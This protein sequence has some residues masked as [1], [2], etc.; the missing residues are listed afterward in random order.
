M[1]G[2]MLDIG[3]KI[4]RELRAKGA[5]IVVTSRSASLTGGVGSL[6]TAAAGSANYIAD[7]QRSKDQDDLLGPERHRLRALSCRAG[8]PPAGRR[9]LVFALPIAHLTASLK[10]H[11]H[12]RRQPRLAD[13][14]GPLGRRRPRRMRRRRRRRPP[15]SLETRQTE[16]PCSANRS[17]SQA[18]FQPAMRPT[19]AFSCLSLACRN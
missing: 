10:S 8:W 3:D 14:A 18:S 15:Q 12:S 4:N 19:T 11:R 7:R 13:R 6:T 1:L 17:T 2:V 16:S 9:R 5:N